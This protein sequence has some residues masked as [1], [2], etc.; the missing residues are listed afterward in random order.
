VHE[1]ELAAVPV[2]LQRRQRGVQAEH[3]VELQEAVVRAGRRQR[4]LRAA[5]GVFGLGIGRNDRQAVHR[6]AQ[7]D[8]DQLLLRGGLRAHQ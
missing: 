5:G 2:A 8:D 1:G 3:R 4:N 6:A 7:H